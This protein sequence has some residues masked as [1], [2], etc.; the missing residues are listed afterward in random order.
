M[1]GGRGGAMNPLWSKRDVANP[2]STIMDPEGIPSMKDV[3]SLTPPTTK[4][5]KKKKARLSWPL[6]QVPYSPN[7]AAISRRALFL[8]HENDDPDRARGRERRQPKCG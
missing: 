4:K 1:A 5:K 6:A 2:I 7:W 3:R 8:P